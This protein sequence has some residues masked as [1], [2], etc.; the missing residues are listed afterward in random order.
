MPF[1]GA[2]AWRFSVEVAG[3]N[4]CVGAKQRHEDFR[5]VRVLQNVPAIAVLLMGQLD[6]GKTRAVRTVTLVQIADII[7]FV[8]WMGRS[9]S[10]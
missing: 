3:L 2:A 4:Q 10:S 7:T 1:D 5:H 9:I 8:D 6:T